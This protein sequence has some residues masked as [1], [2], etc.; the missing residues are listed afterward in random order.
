MVQQ[1]INTHAPSHRGYFRPTR[2]HRLRIFQFF[3]LLFTFVICAGRNVAIECSTP[4]KVPLDDG[5]LPH[6]W[7]QNSI[8]DDED[9]RL[10]GQLDAYTR[11][12]Y[13]IDRPHLFRLFH[14]PSK[15]AQIF[16]DLLAQHGEAYFNSASTPP[17]FINFLS[18]AFKV[19][20]GFA[21]AGIL[22][23]EGPKIFFRCLCNR[24]IPFGSRQFILSLISRDVITI[25]LSNLENWAL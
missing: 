5:C 9:S 8:L 16:G 2:S 6:F 20:L 11:L 3:P 24:F 13:P 7:P 10:R 25:R 14:I 19:V 22:F 18:V 21:P 23:W 17:S 15:I 1:P 12:V 4:K